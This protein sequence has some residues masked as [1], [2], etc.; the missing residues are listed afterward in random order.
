MGGGAKRVNELP[1]E[2]ALKKTL[3][4]GSQV[5]D[6]NQLEKLVEAEE[7]KKEFATL[8]ATASTGISGATGSAMTGS[9]M[10]GS[11]GISGVSGSTGISGSSGATGSAMTGSAMTGSSS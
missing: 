7:K 11:T 2:N 10:T 4:G 8:S 5:V 9:A 1:I 3:K 6:A